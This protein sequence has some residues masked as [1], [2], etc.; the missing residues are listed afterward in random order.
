MPVEKRTKSSLPPKKKRKS[1]NH[2]VPSLE[3]SIST[4]L[5]EGTS[6]NAYADLNNLI[7]A[8]Q[9]PKLTHAVI[10]ALYRSTVLI[11]SKGQLV[12]GK[13]E[14]EEAK[15]VRLWIIARMGEYVENLVGLLK[16]EEK[17]LRVCP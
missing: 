3:Q 17:S 14:S 5:D 12:G 1:N 6:L 16:D 10:Y 11:I 2:D 9:D 8:E 4:A 13:E 15:I 7:S